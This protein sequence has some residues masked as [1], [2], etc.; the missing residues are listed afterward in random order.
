MIRIGSD[1]DIGTNRNSSDWLGMYP[2]PILP[3]GIIIQYY[4]M[5]LRKFND[6]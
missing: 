4:R 6:K 2:N 3:P 1:T 5:F